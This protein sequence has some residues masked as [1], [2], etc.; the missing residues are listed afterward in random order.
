MGESTRA[1]AMMGNAVCP[2]A[3]A[4][5]AHGILA[6]SGILKNVASEACGL[7]CGASFRVETDAGVKFSSAAE[8]AIRMV[9]RACS[10]QEKDVLLKRMQW[11][12]TNK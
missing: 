12:L 9:A 7:S 2:P 5:I 10:E 11:L 6:Y 8:A 4:G 1:Y 3:I